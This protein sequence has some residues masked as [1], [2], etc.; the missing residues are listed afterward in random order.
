MKLLILAV[1][2]SF[3]HLLIRSPLTI[4][5][6]SSTAN[7]NAEPAHQESRAQ[8]TTAIAIDRYQKQSKAEQKQTAAANTDPNYVVWGFWVNAV[9]V[10]AILVIA[11]FAIVQAVAAKLNAKVLMEG[12]AAHLALAKSMQVLD[13]R[14]G[15][16]PEMAIGLVNKGPTPAMDCEVYVW[17]EILPQSA[18][19][20]AFPG[21]T[22][23]V[24]CF[25]V[26]E[27][28]TIDSNSDPSEIVINL[29]HPLTREEAEGL[30]AGDLIL[31]FRL[32]IEYRDAFKQPRYRNFGLFPDPKDG[33]LH[34]LSKYNNSGKG[35]EKIQAN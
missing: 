13:I 11:I 15:V 19:S 29:G 34:L 4:E 21:F 20:S 17:I 26:G 32:Y 14:L 5:D 7:H 6:E 35:K 23:R 30:I 1:L 9:L 28:M 24:F 18:P 25:K 8:I 33:R 22:D 16:D 10:L 12:S 3:S 31:A 2:L 27:R